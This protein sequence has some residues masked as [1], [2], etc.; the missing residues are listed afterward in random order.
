M[1]IESSQNKKK[2]AL[3]QVWV[4]LSPEHQTKVIHLMAKLAL[5]RIMAQIEKSQKEAENEQNSG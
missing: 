1:I 3:N 2:G 4:Q 5:K